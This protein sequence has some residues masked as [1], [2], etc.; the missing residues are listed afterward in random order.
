M[1]SARLLALAVALVLPLAGVANAA[2]TVTVG[3]KAFTE[4]VIL[5]EI[6][7]GALRDAGLATHHRRSLGG[8]RILWQALLKGDIDLYPE[9]TGTIAREILAG[10][11]IGRRSRTI[12][13][14][15]SSAASAGQNGCKA[16]E[17]R[18]GRAHDNSRR[19][20]RSSCWYRRYPR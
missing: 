7:A 20:G 6:A 11:N 18:R 3:S 9:Y 2:E 13:R 16:G 19:P 14:R 12:G 17:T 5:G 4:S 8:T 1:K 15:R 10:K